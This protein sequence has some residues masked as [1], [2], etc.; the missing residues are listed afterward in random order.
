M[1]PY[2]STSLLLEKRYKT[3]KERLR[4][5]RDGPPFLADGSLDYTESELFLLTKQKECFLTCSF[6]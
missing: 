5:E 1:I 2:M 6:L 4:M 3:K